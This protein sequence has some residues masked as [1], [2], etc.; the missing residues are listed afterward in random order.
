[1]PADDKERPGWHVC[2]GCQQP[3]QNHTLAMLKVGT[4]GVIWF[5]QSWRCILGLARQM[6]NAARSAS[7]HA[8]SNQAELERA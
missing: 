5:C 1:M 8:R 6:V 7:E 4:Y 2:I 3:K